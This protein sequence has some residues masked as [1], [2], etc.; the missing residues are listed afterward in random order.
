MSKTGCR[1]ITKSDE[2][3]SAFEPIQN[4]LTESP[5]AQS[6]VALAVLESL[7]PQE[8]EDQWICVNLACMQETAVDLY[9]DIQRIKKYKDNA[10]QSQ[11]A[12]RHLLELQRQFTNDLVKLLNRYRRRTR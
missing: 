5:T 11:E 12:Y 4:F 7:N 6:K 1:A 10:S 8:P 2:K 9:H 3:S